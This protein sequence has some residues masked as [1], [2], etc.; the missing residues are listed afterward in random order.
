[1]IEFK[2]GQLQFVPEADGH[3]DI[4]KCEAEL[5]ELQVPKDLED[6]DPVN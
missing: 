3:L 4:A 6:I 5:R 2:D 1:M